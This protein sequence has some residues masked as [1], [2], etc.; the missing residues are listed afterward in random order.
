MML[1]FGNLFAKPQNAKILNLIY[2]TAA[3]A[4]A[5]VV[6]KSTFLIYLLIDNAYIKHIFNA[7]NNIDDD[8]YDYN[9]KRD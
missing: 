9:A 4:V 5:V 2:C 8:D 6:R 3:D 7:I 1:R